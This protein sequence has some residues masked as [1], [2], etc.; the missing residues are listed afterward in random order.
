LARRM[1]RLEA[2]NLPDALLDALS[3]LL[4]ADA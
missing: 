3:E 4:L 2:L 1:A